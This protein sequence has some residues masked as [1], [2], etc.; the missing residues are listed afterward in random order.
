MNLGAGRIVFQDLTRIDQA[1]AEG[2]LE[3]S[4]ALTTAIDSCTI[5]DRFSPPRRPPLGRRRALPQATSRGAHPAGRSARGT[6]GPGPCVDGR[7]RHGADRWC[8]V[9]RR[10]RPHVRRGRDRAGGDRVRALPRHGPGPAVGP[11]AARLRGDDPR[12]RP[13]RSGCWG[14]WSSRPTRAALRT[15]SSNR[16]SS[17]MPK[18]GRSVCSRTMTRSFSSILEPTAHDNS[19]VPL[20][21]MILTGSS[22]RRHP[23]CGSSR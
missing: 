14:P 10:A 13:A 2:K 12:C 3:T 6:S 9:S 23:R 15:N 5:G 1:I 21:S 17:P 18:T 7:T 16:V 19:P 22:E 20:P 11:H 8:R 4:I